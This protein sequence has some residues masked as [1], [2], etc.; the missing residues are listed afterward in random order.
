LRASLNRN[1]IE[2]VYHAS[3][4]VMT[5]IEFIIAEMGKPGASLTVKANG[6][7][8][9]L[10]AIYS[11]GCLGAVFGAITASLTWWNMILYGVTGV[12]TIIAIL[13]TDGVAFVAEVILV[14]TSFGF[15]A[16]D[17][18]A[19]VGNCSLPAPAQFTNGMRIRDE[20][21]GR[22]SLA[23]DGTLRYIP[24]PQ[25]YINLFK[26]WSSAI[27]VPNVHN[28]LIGEDITNGASLVAGT[29]DGKVFLLL[30][31]GKRWIISPPFLTNTVLP[32]GR[33]KRCLRPLLAP[34]PTA[35]LLAKPTGLASFLKA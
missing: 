30:E 11:G 28:Y 20:S 14:L 17:I 8:D 6:V 26:D 18:V 29:P 32:G 19:A 27:S 35:V 33:S 13:A 4:A 25:T 15:L 23:L 9:I 16:S 7:K 22:I 10:A 12:A 1:A 31:E 24:N 2:G 3:G 21:T 34:Y 5:Q